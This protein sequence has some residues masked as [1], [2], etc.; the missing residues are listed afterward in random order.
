VA[1]LNWGPV[2]LHFFPLLL[3]VS[4]PTYVLF[5]GAHAQTIDVC[6]TNGDT[7]GDTS[8]IAFAVPLT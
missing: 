2:A 8:L 3:Y 4:I 7:D 6:I 1:Q 5:A